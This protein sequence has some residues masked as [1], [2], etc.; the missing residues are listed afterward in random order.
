MIRTT[1]KLLCLCF[2]I[3]IITTACSND[4]SS[5]A[6]PPIVDPEKNNEALQIVVFCFKAIE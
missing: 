3:G 4:D 2:S 6:K 1:I 5:P